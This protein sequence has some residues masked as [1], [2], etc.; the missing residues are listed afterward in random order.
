MN[1][2]IKAG[3]ISTGTLNPRHLVSAF[4]DELAYIGLA[5]P[6]RLDTDSDD[7]YVDVLFCMLADVA[8]DNMYFGAHQGDGADFGFWPIEEIW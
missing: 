2:M 5:P 8:P 4:L 1:N 6:D 3:S 7:E